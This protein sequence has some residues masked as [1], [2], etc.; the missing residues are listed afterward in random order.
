M[1]PSCCCRGGSETRPSLSAKKGRS[2]TCPYARTPEYGRSQTVAQNSPTDYFTPGSGFGL[3]AGA[4]FKSD[5]GRP[6]VVRGGFDSHPFRFFFLK[7]TSPV[8]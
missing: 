3:V 5:G 1:T 7:H 2:E 4:D 6:R 8:K